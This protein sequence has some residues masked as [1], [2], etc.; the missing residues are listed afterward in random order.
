MTLQTKRA[1]LITAVLLII[2]IAV[3]ARI[4]PI[5]QDL[6]YHNFADNKRITGIPNAW[7][8]LSNLPFLIVGGYG[9][10]YCTR[11]RQRYAPYSWPVFFAGIAVISIGSAYYHWAPNN[12]SLIWDRIPMTIAFMGLF[13]GLLSEAIDSKIEK[14]FLIPALFIGVFSVVYWRISDDLRFYGLVQFFPLLLIPIISWLIPARYTHRK[15]LLYGLGFYAVAKIFEL[16]DKP[17]YSL[18]YFSGHSIKHILAAGSA[19]MVLLMII[20]RH[21]ID[22]QSANEHTN[23]P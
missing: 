19:L 20:K 14:I 2:S 11:N 15:Y 10:V 5:Q 13:I 22:K 6:A 23:D 17:I 8:V 21:A 4:N 9:F 12:P 16:Y 3:L 18:I 1:L 7:N